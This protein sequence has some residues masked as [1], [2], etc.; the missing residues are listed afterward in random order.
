MKSVDVLVIGGGI[1]GTGIARDISGRGINVMLCEKGDLAGA[2]SSASTKLIHGGLR[3]LE[4]YEFRLVREALKERE[5]LLKAAPHIIKPLTFVLP[6][7]KNLR[8]WWLIRIG[9]F[10]YDHL[11]GRV[12]LPSSKGINLNS[13][14][15]G[16][17][18]KDI[19]KKGFVYS[20]CWVDDA[21]LVV[22]NAIDAFENGA[23]ILTRMECKKIEPQQDKEGWLVTLFD[24][25]TESE[26]KVSAKLVV[27]AAGPWV[28][29]VL[30]TVGREFI[31]HGIRLV[32][33]SHII[34]KKIYE[35]EQAYIF[36]NEDRRVI[37]V[38]PYEGEY[39]LIGTTDIDYKET[40]EAVRID[41]DEVEY[42]C[43]AVNRFLKHQVKSDD[44]IWAYSGVRPLL[45]DNGSN[46]SAVSR[47]YIIEEDSYEGA[48]IVNIYGGKITTFRMLAENVGNKVISIL[49]KGK[50]AW[51]KNAE[52]PGAEG[53]AANFDTF[54]LIF[55]EEYSWLP[56][57]LAY[58]FAHSYGSRARNLL[59]GFK[60]IT[61]LGAYLGDNIYEAEIRYL[62]RVEWALTI[63]DILFRRSK[64]GLHISEETKANIENILS[65]ILKE[66]E[67]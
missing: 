67:V 11:G 46:V 8:P 50:K 62:I 40:L 38:I 42:L 64:L 43:K 60:S 35:G 23:Q 27:N 61:D 19:F 66:K 63:D 36:Q 39:T 13:D 24:N 9:L 17:P 3:Y 21:R 59:R 16:E 14:E 55:L 53:S 7:H 10:I 37:F 29:K 34:V 49:G 18:L 58:R 26:I 41:I 6:H 31:K 51:T 56:K 25:I 15:F 48:K 54:L 2:T 47:D 1:N 30:G 4:H 5:V 57:D 45:D 20:D 32:K 22:L 12:T 28:N 33:G 44:V 65:L 52:L